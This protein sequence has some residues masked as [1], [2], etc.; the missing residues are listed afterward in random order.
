[1]LGYTGRMDFLARELAG[2]LHVLTSARVSLVEPTATGARVVWTQDGERREE[3]V[4]GVIT[5]VTA[6]RVPEIYPGLEP[7]IATRLH[8][9]VPQANYLALHFALSRRPELD[10]ILVCVP[11]DELGGLSTVVLE[12]N[13][14]QGS[15]PPGKGLV[16]AFPSHE[17]ATSR[18]D[19]PD[20]ELID[21]L[22]PEVE[23]VLGPIAHHI[24]FVEV[25]RWVPAAPR[26]EPGYY[27][28]V[29][30]LHDHLDG[31][32]RVQLAGDFLNLPS[33]NGSIVSGDAAA[34]R[35]A[36]TLLRGCLAGSS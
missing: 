16:C 33:V 14:A 35:L 36:H 9:E 17:W 12:H 29:A 7:A 23:R 4:A 25:I 15:A 11:K 2:R 21:Q 20:H 10:A 22:L 3:H 34:R 27:Q 28:L 31:D 6:Q 13:V 30:D 8:D 19:L 26:P 32:T 1:M 5:S 18:L 24:E